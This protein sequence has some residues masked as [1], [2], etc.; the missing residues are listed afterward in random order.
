MHRKRQKDTQIREESLPGDPGLIGMASDSC[1]N[2]WG[3]TRTLCPPGN[4]TARTGSTAHRRLLGGDTLTER[5]DP[6][7][8]PACRASTGAKVKPCRTTKGGE[9]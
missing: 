8:G 5:F 4:V 9:G 3:R 1:A 7:F 6:D 2:N